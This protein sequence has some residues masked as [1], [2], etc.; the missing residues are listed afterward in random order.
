MSNL[1]RNRI[2]I[3]LNFLQYKTYEVCVKEAN[4]LV[5]KCRR[6]SNGSQIT[7]DMKKICDEYEEKLKR[8]CS[9][10]CA[11]GKHRDSDVTNRHL[12]A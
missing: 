5:G 12:S 1:E 3:I 10:H 9:A 6:D 11:K 8:I 4:V 7:I 2:I